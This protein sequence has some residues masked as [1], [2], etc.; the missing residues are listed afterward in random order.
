MIIVGSN[1]KVIDNSGAKIVGCIRILNK[2]NKKLAKIGDYLVVSVKSLKRNLPKK[3]VTK[4]Q[5]VKAVVVNTRNPKNRKSGL[6][7]KSIRGAVALVDR[8][9]LVPLGTR[10]ERGVANEIRVRGQIKILALA[11]GLL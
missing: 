9:K 11:K 7:L 5:V 4:G 10:I 2:S 8:E 1:L 6:V 3:K